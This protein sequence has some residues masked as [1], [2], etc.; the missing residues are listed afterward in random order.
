M[1]H[2]RIN[3]EVDISIRVLSVKPDIKREVQKG[4]TMSLYSLVF[5]NFI[6]EK[7]NFYKDY[8]MTSLIF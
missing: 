1:Y 4:K 8:N 3:V 5:S 7:T 2:K 6:V